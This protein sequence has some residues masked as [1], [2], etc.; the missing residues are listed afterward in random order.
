VFLLPLAITEISFG[1][2]Y[3]TSETCD[4]FIEL[5]DWLII[6]G[7]ITLVF[8]IVAIPLYMSGTVM[9]VKDKDSCAGEC[10]ACGGFVLMWL[11]CAFQFAWLI[12][13]SV[14]FWRDC[15]DVEPKRVNTL[16][17]CSLIIGYVSLYLQLQQ[18]NQKE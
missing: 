4:S 11:V 1:N 13:G 3:D 2:M 5:S 16:M 9:M 6:K 12:V 10:C 15:H 7:V 17:W 14:V 8:A 18:S